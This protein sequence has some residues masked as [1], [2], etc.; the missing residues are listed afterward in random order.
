[1]STM[2]FDH[3]MCCINTDTCIQVKRDAN[4]F[5]GVKK[6]STIGVSFLLCLS[7]LQQVGRHEG[8]KHTYIISSSTFTSFG[9]SLLYTDILTGSYFHNVPPLLTLPRK[10]LYFPSHTHSTAAPPISG[11]RCSAVLGIVDIVRAPRCPVRCFIAVLKIFLGFMKSFAVNNFL[12]SH[13]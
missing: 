13:V 7:Q 5:Y 6:L 9:S 8:R 3:V 4:D 10:A 11:T 12:V 1:M 2:G